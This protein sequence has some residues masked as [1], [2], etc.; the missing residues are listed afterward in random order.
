MAVVAL[1]EVRLKSE[2]L[3]EAYAVVTETLADTRKFAGCVNAEV[4][5]DRTDP[6]HLVVVETWE[7]PE[8]DAAYREWRR[9]DGAPV[10]LA[11]VLAAP[12]VLT[13]FDPSDTL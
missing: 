2:G 8:A 12:P 4:L 3:D 5:I 11:A 10:K 9:G 1:L 6:T 13:L 7:S